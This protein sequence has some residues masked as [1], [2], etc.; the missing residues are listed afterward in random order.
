M[1]LKGEETLRQHPRVTA[2]LKRK[3]VEQVIKLYEAWD[4]P[5]EAAEWRKKYPPSPS[6]SPASKES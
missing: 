3:A 6:P 5:A 2:R 1:L 4:K